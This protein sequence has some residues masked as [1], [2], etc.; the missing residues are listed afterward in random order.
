M[1]TVCLCELHIFTCY[2]FLQVTVMSLIKWTKLNNFISGILWN[3]LTI[4]LE[5]GSVRTVS[6]IVRFIVTQPRM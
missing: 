6:G 5:K 4:F 1:Y 3:T 2:K